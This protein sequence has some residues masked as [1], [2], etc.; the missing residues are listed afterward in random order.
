MSQ[1]NVED[2]THLFSFLS[3]M[4]Q[5]IQ[6]ALLEEQ[7]RANMLKAKEMELNKAQDVSRI[8]SSDLRIS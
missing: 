4:Q 6:A 8:Q 3:K 2:L 5:Q 7:K 1:D